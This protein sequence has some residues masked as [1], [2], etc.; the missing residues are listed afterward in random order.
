MSEETFYHVGLAVTDIEAAMRELSA[1]RGLTW[2]KVTA[3]T[4]EGH[5]LK[6]TYSVEGPPHIELIQGEPGGPWDASAGPHTH[7]VGQFTS[8]LRADR[9]RIEEAGMKLDLAGRGF[10]YH[11]GRLSGVTLELVA[12][13][14]RPTFERWL[15]GGDF[16]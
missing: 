1:A 5:P 9:A 2:A 6:F 8:D 12:E 10:T 16:I 13:G 11:S 3:L 4:I 15:A 14:T 7:H